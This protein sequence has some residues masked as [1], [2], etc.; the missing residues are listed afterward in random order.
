MIGIGV[1]ELLIILVLLGAGVGLVALIVFLVMRAQ[2]GGQPN[3]ANHP[4][5]V[6]CHDCG[7]QI[8]M[9]ATKCPHCGGPVTAKSPIP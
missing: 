5:L 4:N 8:S 2:R 3:P 7:Q 9:N 1:L 6:P